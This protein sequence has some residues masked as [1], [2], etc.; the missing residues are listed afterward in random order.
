MRF[1]LLEDDDIPSNPSSARLSLEAG[2]G[3]EPLELE[4]GRDVELESLCA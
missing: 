1:G 4:D 3:C 2:F